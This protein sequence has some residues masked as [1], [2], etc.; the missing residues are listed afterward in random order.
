MV[1]MA[2]AALEGG[3]AAIRANGPI[4]IAAIRAAVPLPII[5]LYKEDLAGFSV[6][7]TP[8]LEHALRLAEAGAGMI[9]LDATDR[10][11]PGG[12]D[13]G[14]LI[15]QVQRATGLPVLA[16]ISTEA[17]ALAAG[18]AGAEAVSTTLSGYTPYSPSQAGPDLALVRA[19]AAQLRIPVIAEGR[20]RTPQEARQALDL[21]SFAVVV[22]AAITRP[23][24]I[25]TQ[26]RLVMTQ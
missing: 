8:T 18:A 10:P 24:W 11:H 21:G 17:E 16:D 13:A 4:D 1:A 25:T 7:I 2:Q 12:V 19:L 23:Q 14:A 20:I 3:A 9:A 26:F 5:G 6:R 22:G 15:Q